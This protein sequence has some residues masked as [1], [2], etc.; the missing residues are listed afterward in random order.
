MRSGLTA[1][2]SSDKTARSASLPGAIEPFACS[3]WLA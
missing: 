1:V 3:A 2:G